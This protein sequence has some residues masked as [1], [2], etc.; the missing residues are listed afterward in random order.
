MIPFEILLNA[1]RSQRYARIDP[2][3]AI[4]KDLYEE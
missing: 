4:E 3:L 2:E 1:V